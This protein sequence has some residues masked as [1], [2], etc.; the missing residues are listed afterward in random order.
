MTKLTL[1]EAFTCNPETGEI[2]AL[3]RRNGA[4][5]D[6]PLGHIRK[7]T[8]PYVRLSL[9]GRNLYAHRIVWELCK[10]PIPDGVEID[11]RNGN[12][13]DNRLINL[14]AVNHMKNMKNMRIRAT[15]TLGVAGIV[16]D[17]R[18]EKFAARIQDHRGKGIHLGYFDTVEPAIAARKAAEPLYGYFSHA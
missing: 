3:A 7:G 13:L 11:H 14:R 10:G 4:P 12:S 1:A 16:F 17:K 15:N 5:R 2:F 8:R 18:R 9:Q 6:K